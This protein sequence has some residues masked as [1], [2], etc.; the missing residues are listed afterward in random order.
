M[1]TGT[2]GKMPKHVPHKADAT[3]PVFIGDRE[4]E[5]PKPDGQYYFDKLSSV[6]VS[7]NKTRDDQPSHIR[8]QQHVPRDLAVMWEAMCPAKVYEVEENGGGD[9]VDVKVNPSNCVQCGAIT[10][11]GAAHSAGG[12]LGA[13]V[14]DHLSPRNQG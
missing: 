8:V 9:M 6:F 2:R 4:S 13:R 7:G 3:G 14:H 5:Y 11:K 1:A 12:R 10:A